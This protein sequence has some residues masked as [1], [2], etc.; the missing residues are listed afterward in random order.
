MS[1]RSFI[2]THITLLILC[3]FPIYFT[4][5]RFLL[6]DKGHHWDTSELLGA[7]ATC[8]RPEVKKDSKTSLS[9]LECILFPDHSDNI[10]DDESRLVDTDSDVEYRNEGAIASSDG[11]NDSGIGSCIEVR[12]SRFNNVRRH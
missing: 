11:S 2:T 9:K 10:I 6:A 4:A 12:I 8:K 1:I 5:I 7:T 3:Q